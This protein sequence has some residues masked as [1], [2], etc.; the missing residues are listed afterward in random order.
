MLISD[1]LLWTKDGKNGPDDP[2]NSMSILLRWLTTEGNYNKYRGGPTS[3]G[4]G[5]IHW[6]TILSKDMRAVG[7][8]K[9]RSPKAIKNKITNMEDAFKTAHDWANQTGAGLKE[10]DPGQFNG[11]IQ[12]KCPYYFDLLEVMQDRTTSRR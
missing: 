2:T 12:K 11:Y 4:K 9:Y 3:F 1:R 6:C 8:R 10:G 5:K 7:I